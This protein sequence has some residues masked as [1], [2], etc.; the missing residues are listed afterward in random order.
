[1][2]QE[3]KLKLLLG[4]YVAFMLMANIFGAKIWEVPYPQ[5]IQDLLSPLDN[6]IFTFGSQTIVPFSSKRISFSVGLFALPILFLITDIVAE[7]KGDKAARDIFL[8]GL[9]CLV[10]LFLYSVLAVNLPPAKRFTNNEAYVSVFG[11]S[12]RLILASF[13]AF[14]VAQSLDILLFE[15]LKQVT[16]GKFLWLRNNLSTFISQFVDTAVF[17]AAA[18]TKLPFSIPVLGIVAGQGF[19]LDF[20]VKL[21]IPYYIF[22][23]LFALLDTPFCYLGVKWLRG[24]N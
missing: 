19:D 13:S 17:Y 15:K 4:L 9:I 24:K 7:V 20:M 5:F 14:V 16:V 3:F 11:Q 2:S 18:F 10:C 22:K 23:V 21:F 6:L 12:I 1:V 8:V